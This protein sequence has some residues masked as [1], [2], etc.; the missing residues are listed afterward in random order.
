MSSVKMAA[1][2][3]R[4]RW[5]NT[6]PAGI[7]ATQGNRAYTTMTLTYLSRNILV[8]EPEG[9]HFQVLSFDA[10]SYIFAHM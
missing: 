8:S 7:Q 1:I 6:M 3:S 4:G 10:R 5:V 2:L 9:V